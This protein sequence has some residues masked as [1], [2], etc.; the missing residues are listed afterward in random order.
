[1]KVKILIVDDD[2][3]IRDSLEGLFRSEG[4][5]VAT[6]ANGAEAL[7]SLRATSLPC[8]VILDLTMPVLDGAQT[9]AQM[10]ADPRLLGLPVFIFTSDDRSLPIG[11]TAFRKPSEID[12]LLRAVRRASHSPPDAHPHG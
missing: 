1:M 6:A 7:E 2:I 8:A 9:Y 12:R 10:Q 11:A 5:E 4:F 3:D